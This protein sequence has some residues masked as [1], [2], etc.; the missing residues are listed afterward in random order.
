MS[1]RSSEMYIVKLTC[2]RV[3]LGYGEVFEWFVYMFCLYR[4]LFRGWGLRVFRFD[5]ELFSSFRS[6]SGKKA[7]A[8]AVLLFTQLIV[9]FVIL[10]N[11]QFKIFQSS[12]L[13]KLNSFPISA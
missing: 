11:T 13:L 7:I 9:R 5:S 2:V 4:V 10:P 6:R 1:A 8:I 12:A 3:S